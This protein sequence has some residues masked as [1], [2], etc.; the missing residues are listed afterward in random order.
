M[1]RKILMAAGA[2]TILTLTT[3]CS[4]SSLGG[5]DGSSD[6]GTVKL[7]F[8]VPKTGVYAGIG[9][10][11]ERGVELYLDL[12]D[13]QLGGRDVELVTIDEGSTTQAGTAA[14]QRLVD[15]E[16]VDVATGVVN[17][18]TAAAIAPTF[19][20]AEIPMLST[21]QVEDND[22]WWRVGWTNPAMNQSILD[23]IAENHADD[24]VYL[25]ASDYKQGHDVVKA[26]ESGL[27]DA[28]V[29]VAGSTFTPFG[30]TQDYQP[31]LSGI[32]KAGATVTYAFYAGAE[33]I[34]FVTQYDQFGLAE[35]IPLVANQAVTEGTLAAQKQAA[36]G[37]VTNSIY[38]A[39]LETDA[40]Q[41]FVDAYQEA[42]DALPSVY[43]EAQ[44]SALVAL[45]AALED[46]D[47]TVQEALSSLGDVDSPRGTWRFDDSNAPTQTIYVRRATDRD[48][49]M[50][51]EV[52]GE[53]GVY[54][55]AGERQ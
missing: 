19:A 54:S 11:L 17:S 55:G 51:N 29:D 23:Y 20:D 4:G 6:D 16:Q 18:A 36:E 1:N 14:A 3:S 21:A 35:D 43:S 34:Q 28:G 5:D 31:Y 37:V 49:A 47:V 26:I 40:N 48:G 39:Y 41:E 45:D 10:D 46:G 42:Y 32:R 9:T 25:I 27:E 38:S 12:H 2:A 7:G 8:I 15:R 52:V 24:S 44:Y 53:I 22:Y 30:T 13:N 50:I 33:A